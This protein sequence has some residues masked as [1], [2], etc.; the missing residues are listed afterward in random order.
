MT[1]SASSGCIM[2][3][4]Y[5]PAAVPALWQDGISYGVVVDLG[6]TQIRRSL[7]DMEKGRRLAGR[8]GLN[9]QARFGADV[10]TRIAAAAESEA[11]PR[12]ISRWQ[13]MPQGRHSRRS[14]SRN[15]PTSG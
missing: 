10:L 7:G 4:F 13:G 5:S 1:T 8:C 3:K 2:D 12:E 6:T 9:P 11:R 15:A 14:P